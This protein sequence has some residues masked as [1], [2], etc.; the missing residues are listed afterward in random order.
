LP[1]SPGSPIINGAENN[2]LTAKDSE[3]MDIEGTYT[4]Q[5]TPEVVWV[6]LMDLETL[7][8]TIPGIEGLERLGEDTYTF[9]LHI[10]HAPLR[11][12]YAGH[13]VAAKLEYPFSYQMRAEGEGIPGKFLAE[14]ITMLKA[15]DENTVI[16]YQGSLHFSRANALL[17]SPLIKGTIKVLIQ[18]FFTALADH[19]RSAS[20]SYP[21]TPEDTV[22]Q[23]EVSHIHNGRLASSTVP[24]QPT[25]PHAIVRQ[26]GLGDND[27]LLEQQ[28][29]NRL[30]RIGFVAVLLLLVWVGTRL[31]GNLARLFADN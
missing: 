24:V 22:T 26:L 31:P 28:W 11:G 25:F 7:R 17:P 21:A 3:E 27:P 15:L 6:Q 23:L 9:T 16:A 8:R 12:S 20:Y 5:A 13:A 29:V 14:W 2:V 19:L 18:Q 10:K 4:L 1:A 30:R